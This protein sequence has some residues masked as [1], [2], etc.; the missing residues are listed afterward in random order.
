SCIDRAIEVLSSD[1]RGCLHITALLLLGVAYAQQGDSARAAECHQRILSITEACGESLFRST[2]LGMT[3]IAAW[4]QG[5]NSRAQ[6]LLRESLRLNQCMRSLLVAALDLEVLAWLA[7]GTDD[8]RSAALMGA[9]ANMMQTAPGAAI[10]FP[11]M[12]EAHLDC[13]RAVRRA[14]GEARFDAAWRRGHAMRINAVVAYALNE[15]QPAATPSAGGTTLTKRERQVADLVAEGLTNKQIASRLVISQRTADAHV[16]HI[17]T[18]LGF[19]SRAQIAA[20]SVD[21][22][23][24]EG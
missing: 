6:D 23:R 8:Q 7:A 24:H 22:A 4:Q 16:E 20:W 13:E 5:E 18:K 17:L 21:A 19:T 14:L 3:G 9:A 11:Q 2:A 1:P 12:V 10:Y 15:E